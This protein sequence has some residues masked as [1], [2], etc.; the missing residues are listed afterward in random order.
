M[1]HISAI[2]RRRPGQNFCPAAATIEVPRMTPRKIEYERV[3]TGGSF[4]ETTWCRPIAINVVQGTA[5]KLLKHG[6]VVPAERALFA[7]FC[8]GT[9]TSTCSLTCTAAVFIGCWAECK[10]R[11][12]TRRD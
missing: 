1:G 3:S 4:F 9:R 5:I 8:A 12:A 7:S 11:K 6:L 2:H 10:A